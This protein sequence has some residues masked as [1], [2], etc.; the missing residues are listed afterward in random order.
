[1]KEELEEC[2]SAFAG[3]R[4]SPN[5]KILLSALEDLLDLFFALKSDFLDKNLSFLKDLQTAEENILLNLDNLCHMKETK[6]DIL[7]M[8][9]M[10]GDILITLKSLSRKYK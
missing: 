5:L 7:K 4:K 2:I 10:T 1:M 8:K 3:I 9:I 6:T